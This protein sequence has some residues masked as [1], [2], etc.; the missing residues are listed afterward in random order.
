MYLYRI[1]TGGLMYGY[2]AHLQGS[3]K[4]LA[5]AM[6]KV[7]TGRNFNSYAEDPAAASKAFQ[8]RR[9]HW[10]NA[11]QSRNNANVYSTFSQAYDTID[12]V[13]N[14]LG[15]YLANDGTL[16]GLN[17][18]DGSGRNA[19]GQA[20]AEAANA[21]VQSMNANYAGNFIFAGADGLNVPF[22]WSEDG[23]SL[24]Y[25]GVDVSGNGTKLDANG[26]KISD[27]GK[28]ALEE[29]NNE[30]TY[31]DIGLGMAE[32]IDGQP[33]VST[34]YNSALSGIDF[35]GY[36]TDEDGDPE[37][38]IMIMKQISDILLNCSSEDGKF[39]KPED[40]ETLNRLSKKLQT[41]L[42]D[43]NTKFVELATKAQFLKTN[44]TKLNAEKDTLNEQVL[45]V[46]QMSE[47]EAISNMIYAQY[48]YNA[49]LKIGM[50]LLSESLI[51]YM[52]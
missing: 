44:E 24:L 7:E 49:A 22:K 13:K 16:V 35:L 2:K 38:A 28:V 4:K 45:D 27:G 46:E 17:T 47:A 37:N 34:V 42:D 40:E 8:L 3:Y 15:Y 41:S 5:D 12:Q 20:I 1:T 21:A 23:Q 31:V 36:G 11:A 30:T 19:L 33:V 32:T 50:N 25:R 43:M 6:E 26:Q 51:D 39:A 52:R 9:D 14:K 48:S 18:P 29:M 10:R